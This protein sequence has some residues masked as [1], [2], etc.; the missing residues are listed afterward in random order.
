M[1]VKHLIIG[2]G[3]SGCS[4]AYNLAAKG[5]DSILV[6]DKSYLTS[7]STGRCG[8]GVRQQWGTKMNCLLAKASIEFFEKAA[9][10]LEYP[11]DIEFKQEGYLILAVT[12]EED[13]DFA[14]NVKLQNSLGIPSRKI[15]KEEALA[16]VP[17]LNPDSFLSATF[18]PT[19]GHLNPFKMTDAYYRKA[20]QLGAEFSFHEEVLEIECADHLFRVKTNKRTI[21]AENLI[22]ASG[23]QAGVIG[24]MAELDLPVHAERH[25]VLIT[26]PIERIQ[27]PMVMS[28][29]KNI[30]CQQVPHGGF[31]MGRSDPFEP[32]SFRLDSSWQFLDAMAKTVCE[33]LPPL[34]KLRVTRQWAGSYTMTP[35]RQP[36]IG[37]TPVPGFY[38]AIGFSGHGFMFA[39]MTGLLLA[40]MILGEETSLPIEE[41]ALQRFESGTASAYEKS[42]V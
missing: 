26:E 6:L 25:E 1:K 10:I 40:E 31:I 30:Y 14:R 39:P 12:E 34:G 33:I 2:V 13:R 20:K 15:T 8:A 28:F 29:G 18:C 35:D 24:K 19:D 17:H 16:I 9:E 21:E 32:P 23:P 4:I 42:V 22:N 38:V 27:G 37:R 41:L 7:G 3:I 11:G 36:I 5:E